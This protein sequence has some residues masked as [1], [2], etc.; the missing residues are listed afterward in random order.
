MSVP[1]KGG[2]GMVKRASRKLYFDEKYK[3]KSKVYLS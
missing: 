3:Y 1:I 2:S